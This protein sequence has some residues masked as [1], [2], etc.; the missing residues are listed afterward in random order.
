M[1]NLGK[2][3]NRTFSI[4]RDFTVQQIRKIEMV[5]VRRYR[6]VAK[7]Y[8]RIEFHDGSW[9]TVFGF[10]EGNEML[11]G[12]LKNWWSVYQAP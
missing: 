12:F 10:P 9:F 8:V 2:T 6:K 7:N 11:Y 4:N 1:G 3:E 5:A